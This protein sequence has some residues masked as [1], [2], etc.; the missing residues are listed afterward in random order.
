M[1][2]KINYN[3]HSKYFACS[4]EAGGEALTVMCENVSVFRALSAVTTGG[5][6]H[7]SV[8]VRTEVARLLDHIVCALGSVRV[9][10]CSKDFLETLMPNGAKLL[11][12]GSIE[13]RTHAKHMFGELIKHDKFEWLTKEYLR[14]N[15]RRDIKKTLDSLYP[16]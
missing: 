10:G 8:V 15:E 9:V 6:N 16:K 1:V 11:T 5:I 12:D 14:E 13:V 3:I 2:G 4:R 7:K